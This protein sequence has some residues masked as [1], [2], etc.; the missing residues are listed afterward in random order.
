MCI[1]VYGLSCPFRENEENWTARFGQWAIFFQLLLALVASARDNT[2]SKGSW[3][4]SN[5]QVW[6]VVLIIIN[7]LVAFLVVLGMAWPFLVR[8]WT[9]RE[10]KFTLEP[11]SLKR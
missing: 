4:I 5:S 10:K 7:C 9:N 11:P 1:Y 6:G 2:P 8:W 3:N